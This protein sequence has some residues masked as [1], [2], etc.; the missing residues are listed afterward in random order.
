MQI[1]ALL[2]RSQCRVSD[3]RTQVA[4]KAWGLLFCCQIGKTYLA[5]GYITTRRCIA[6]IHALDMNLS[7]TFNLNIKFIEF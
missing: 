1:L 5:Y 4:V 3:T 2:T 7:L 6:Y